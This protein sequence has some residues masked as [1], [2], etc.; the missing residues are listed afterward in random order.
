MVRG[1]HETVPLRGLKR[2]GGVVSGSDVFVGS[3]PPEVYR[4]KGED[5]DQDPDRKEVTDTVT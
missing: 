3:C 1:D 5:G 4:G 2:S